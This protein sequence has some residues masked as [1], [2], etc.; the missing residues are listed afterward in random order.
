[1][2]LFVVISTFLLATSASVI[3]GPGSRIIGGQYASVGQFPYQVYLQTEFAN[4]P[5][6]CGASILSADWVVTAG[7]CVYDATNVNVV[8][9]TIS[10]NPFDS[11]AQ[12]RSVAQIINHPQYNPNSPNY[13]DISLL[14]LSSPLSLN[15]YIWPVPL[16]DKYEDEDELSIPEKDTREI[17]INEDFVIRS[18]ISN[19]GKA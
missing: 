6:W 7:H 18:R 2:K 1:M 4:G 13:N 3:K 12:I 16:A 9:G 17:H 15:Y 10:V 14:R 8:A 5:S 11:T 19:P